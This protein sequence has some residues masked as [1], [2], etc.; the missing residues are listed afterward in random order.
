MLASTLVERVK[1]ACKTSEQA[2]LQGE[3]NEK[4]A[5]AVGYG[6]ATEEREKAE[7]AAKEAAEEAKR[8]AQKKIVEAQQKAIEATIQANNAKIAAQNAKK[9]AN[10]KDRRQKARVAHEKWLMS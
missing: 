5:W 9:Q 4:E 8:E 1:Y 6:R 10:E 7:Q 2:R 3:Q